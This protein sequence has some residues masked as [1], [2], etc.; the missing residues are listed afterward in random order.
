MADVSVSIE[1]EAK[2]TTLQKAGEEIAK[3]IQKKLG[4]IGMGEGKKMP[5]AGGTMQD[6][7]KQ[8][9]VIG[10]VAGGIIGL[11]QMIVEVLKDFPLVT[12]IM[13]LLKV[14]LMLLFMPLIPILK[15]I[16]LLLGLLAKLMIKGLV[17]KSPIEE[18]GAII[19]AIAL[20]FAAIL[21]GF[22]A[23]IVL[24]IVALGAALGLLAAKFGEWLRGV[25]PP[26]KVWEF[27]VNSF[28][29][30]VNGIV[31]IAKWIWE[32]LKKGFDILINAGV[33]IWEN[34]LK[35]AFNFLVDVGLWIWEQIL[36]PAL[37]WLS[38]LGM[39]IWNFLVTLFGG[40]IDV[41]TVVWE[42]LKTLWTGTIDVLA[43]V[44]DFIKGLFKG[45]IDVGSQLLGWFKGL[46]GGTSKGESVDD[47][48]ISGGKIITTNPNDYLIATKTPGAMGGGTV[49]NINID[50]PTVSSERDIKELVRQI[51]LA[52]QTQYRA[53]VSY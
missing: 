28:M 31:F 20:G 2:G 40:T 53:R 5:S 1:I 22:P 18:V 25:L 3:G 46:F 51:S 29:W 13:K 37:N 36:K 14:I 44:W 6:S 41:L 45:T 8:G 12:A 16:L 38:D 17:A 23:A 24:L 27:I 52:L 4:I 42:W 39:K 50:K 21:S 10:M 34:I 26:A 19:G 43:V 49:I 15:P 47:A 33:W 30:L 11:I 9:V 48:I 35:P 32:T 7:V